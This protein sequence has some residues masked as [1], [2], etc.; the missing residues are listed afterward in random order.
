MTDTSCDRTPS[1]FSVP[2]PGVPSRLGSDW[3]IVF[4][5]GLVLYVATCAPDILM[6]DPGVPQLRVPA[7]PPTPAKLM[8]DNLVQVHPFYLA[9]AKVFTWIP[10]GNLAYRV[11]L[12]SACFG[13]L[14]LASVF[15]CSRVLTGSRWAAAIGTLSL[16]LGHTFWAY[17]V[18]AES[19]TLVTACFSAEVLFL[20][21]FSR[22]RRP[23][24]IMLVALINGLS[25]SNHLLGGLAT[26]VY[27][28]LMIIGWVRGRLRGADIG[29][30]L[31]L[32]VL[33]LSPYL[34]LIVR[35]IAETGQILATLRSATTGTWGAANVHISASMIAKVPLYLVLQY[36]TLLILLCI[37]AMWARPLHEGDGSLRWAVVCVGLIHFVFAARYPIVDQYTYFIPFYACAA[38]LIALGAQ[39]IIH[40]WAWTRWVTLAMTIVPVGVYMVLPSV[41]RRVGVTPFTRAIAYRDPYVFWLKPWQQG[42]YGARQYVDEAFKILPKDAILFA[43][44]TPAVA[45]LYVQEIEKKRPDVKVVFGW[46]RLPL[47]AL[48]KAEVPS[49][50]PRWVR[51]VYV[52]DTRPPFAPAAFV[53]DCR[54]VPEGILYRVVAPE[55]WPPKPWR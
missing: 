12:A 21:M 44:P 36:P 30:C 25:I 55:K 27:A 17:S 22:T 47:D 28:V 43:D 1:V 11:N 49:F 23:M 20:V 33:G 35:Q 31:G 53:R 9:A 54:L 8:K 16:G 7:F 38:F 42:Y 19:L 2:S 5:M 39:V 26:P 32:W 48:L 4:A 24:W 15:V 10:V 29:C 51:P 34:F 50:V 45:F 14:S 40:R 3:L 41:A 37:P 46:D 52:V 18:M 13:A 6:G